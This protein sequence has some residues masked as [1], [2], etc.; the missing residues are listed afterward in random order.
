MSARLTNIRRVRLCRSVGEWSFYDG[1]SVDG[2][3][4]EDDYDSELRY[5]GRAVPSLQGLDSGDRVIFLGSFSTICCPPYV[6]AI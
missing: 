2:F 1:T 3:I 6:S 4:I 5:S